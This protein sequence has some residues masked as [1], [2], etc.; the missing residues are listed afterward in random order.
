MIRTLFLLSATA[1]ACLAQ[2]ADDDSKWIFASSARLVGT[3]QSFR[4]KLFSWDAV[5]GVQMLYESPTEW[6]AITSLT[7]DGSLAALRLS[8]G[9]SPRSHGALFHVHTGQIEFVG[10]MAVISRNGR[11]LYTGDALIDRVAG[12]SR[13]VSVYPSFV[14]SD[15]SILHSDGRNLHRLP[16][17]QDATADGCWATSRTASRPVS[18]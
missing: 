12:T 6:A 1:L 18:R 14:G 10:T 3:N 16:F 15:G 7:G 2:I 9:D 17:E 11:Y 8:P 4:S 13:P 5:K